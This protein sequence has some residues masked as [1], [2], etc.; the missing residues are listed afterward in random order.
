MSLGRQVTGPTRRALDLDLTQPNQVAAYRSYTEGLLP[1]L[2]NTD[3]PDD[4]SLALRSLCLDSAAW[5]GSKDDGK[6]AAVQAA[7]STT[8][9]KAQLVALHNIY[10]HLH[11]HRGHTVW[12]SQSRM[13]SALPSIIAAWESAVRRLTWPSLAEAGSWLDCSGY[14]PSFWRC[15]MDLRRQIS[16]ATRARENLCEQGK[17]KRVIASILQKL[18]ALHSLQLDQGM[19]TDAPTLHNMVTDHLTAWYQAP[20]PSVDWPQLLR[21]PTAF[22]AHAA[23]SPCT[24]PNNYGRRLQ[25]HSSTPSYS[26]RP[27]TLTSAAA[28]DSPQW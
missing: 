6:R 17:L 4:A 14:S 23:G 10:G 26:M 21:D 24:Y 15:A 27:T 22:H 25:H 20:G 19:L 16:D 3:S 2:P 13:D 1:S 18:Y 8:S 9:L 11:G 5:G 28:I 12:H 7:D